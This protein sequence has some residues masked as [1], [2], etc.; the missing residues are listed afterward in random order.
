[1]AP[2][3]A[4][5]RND[6]R[7]IVALRCGSILLAWGMVAA[8]PRVVTLASGRIDAPALD[9]HECSVV[10]GAGATL[11]LH[12]A[13]EPCRVARELVGR[14]GTLVIIADEREAP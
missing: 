2:C 7:G 5:A 14:S 6:V 10:I 9:A 3:G 8:A 11:V 1:M 4:V 12:P 13:G